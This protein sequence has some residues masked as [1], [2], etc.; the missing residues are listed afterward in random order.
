MFPVRG[1]FCL[2]LPNS[3]VDDDPINALSDER[4]DALEFFFEALS[5]PVRVVEHARVL[6]FELLQQVIDGQR[7]HPH[8][9][10]HRLMI[11]GTVFDQDV[12]HH[13]CQ[14]RDGV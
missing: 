6:G 3:D 14:F 11:D 7:D 2:V 5:A 12:L 10:E 9:H 8:P 4:S 13:L 1:E